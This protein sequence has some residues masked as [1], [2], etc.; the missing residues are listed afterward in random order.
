MPTHVTPP[1]P[2][3]NSLSSTRLAPPSLALSTAK[4]L[5]NA[6]KS[7]LFLFQTAA[8]DRPD[9]PTRD[10]SRLARPTLPCP[11]LPDTQITKSNDQRFKSR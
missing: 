5:K 2:K 10:T 8:L 1:P 9:R 6:I 3:S 7:I 11:A 4:S